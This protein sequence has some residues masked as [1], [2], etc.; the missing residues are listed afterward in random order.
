V[1]DDATGHDDSIVDLCG[2]L[3]DDAKLLALAEIGRIRAIIFRR[4]VKGRMAIFFMVASAL[5]AQSA[6]LILLLGMLMYLRIHVGILGATAIV[7]VVA[8]LLSLLFGWFAFH[9]VKRAL[10]REDDLL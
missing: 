10:S 6:V 9:R 7:M 2:Q 5:L 3:V 8:M 1:N 4:L